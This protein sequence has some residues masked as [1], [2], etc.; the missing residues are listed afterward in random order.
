MTQNS[1]VAIE[2]EYCLVGLTAAAAA[3]YVELFE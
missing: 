3:G 1:V 2:S